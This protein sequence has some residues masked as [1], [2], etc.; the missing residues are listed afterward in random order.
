MLVDDFAT[1][2]LRLQ[3]ANSLEFLEVLGRCLARRYP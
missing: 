1:A 2:L 3:Y